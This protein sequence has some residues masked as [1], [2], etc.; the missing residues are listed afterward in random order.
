M[1]LVD[2]GVAAPLYLFA[3][4]QLPMAYSATQ[5]D[6]LLEMLRPVWY[7]TK[8]RLANI[9]MMLVFVHFISIALFC[10]ALPGF[11]IAVES[12]S[13]HQPSWGS[14]W[15]CAV[16]WASADR[17]I[18]AS[19]IYLLMYI[20]CGLLGF[21]QIMVASIGY[22]MCRQILHTNIDS[23]ANVYSIISRCM[24]FGYKFGC[25]YCSIE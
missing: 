23:F 6:V 14:M 11:M 7:S 20:L 13:L 3:L 19:W 8:F 15:K 2:C 22:C 18:I 25:Q 16:V 4:Y 12:A 21:A 24:Q 5:A 9:A 10:L 17:Y 1:C